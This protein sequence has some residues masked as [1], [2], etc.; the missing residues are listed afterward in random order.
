VTQ[1]KKKTAA[2]GRMTQATIAA[3]VAEIDAHRRGERAGKLSWSILEEFSGFS[4]VSLWSK[5]DIKSAFN[6]AREALRAD[7]TPAM[8]APRTSDE[9]LAVTQAAL[10]EA[11]EIIRGY[12]E[13]WAL[14]EYNILRLGLDADELRRPL[15]P[16]N[17]VLV[18]RRHGPTAR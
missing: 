2:K 15:D 14:Y 11:R 13:L 18:R 9:R 3:V 8:K 17:R 16:V 1:R 10:H 4:H 12:D 7:S 6:A 5:P